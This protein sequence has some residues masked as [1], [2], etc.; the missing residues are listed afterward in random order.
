ML[1][2][3]K[4]IRHHVL[5]SINSNKKSIS[6]VYKILNINDDS[7]TLPDTEHMK[8]NVVKRQDTLF[9]ESSKFDYRTLF[10]EGKGITGANKST[11]RPLK[12]PIALDF[13]DNS[14]VKGT[15]VN[16]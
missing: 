5:Q 4:K 11:Q 10:E 13:L 12:L 1:L 8:N 2:S 6:L 15:S 16:Q 14:Q 9:P 3:I 7:S